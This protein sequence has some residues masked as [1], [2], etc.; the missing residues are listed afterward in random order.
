M[1][2]RI[3]AYDSFKECNDCSLECSPKIVHFITEHLLNNE[4]FANGSSK[5]CTIVAGVKAMTTFL[6]SEEEFNQMRSKLISIPEYKAVFLSD[7]EGRSGS[8]KSKKS[9]ASVEGNEVATA[10][11]SSSSAG[12]ASEQFVSLMRIL[13]NCIQTQG[14]ELHSI[15]VPNKQSADKEAFLQL[16]SCCAMT[17]IKL[18]NF[19]KLISVDEWHQ[20]AWT[21]LNPSPSRRAEIWAV[22][23]GIIQT[24]PVHSKFLAYPCLLASDEALSAGAGAALQKAISRLRNTHEEMCARLVK[25]DSERSRKMAEQCIPEAVLPYVLHLLS[26]H[27]DFPTTPECESESDQRRL[28][29][30]MRSIR[31]VITALQASLRNEA[32]NISYLLKQLNLI[33]Q[34]Y[35]DKMDAENIGLHFVAGVA[36]TMLQD[37]VKTAENVQVYPGEIT[38]PGDLFELKPEPDEEQASAREELEAR[39]AVAEIQPMIDKAIQ[40]AGKQRVKALPKYMS[41]PSSKLGF[42]AAVHR[43]GGSNSNRSVTSSVESRRSKY[44]EEKDHDADS[45]IAGRGLEEDDEESSIKKPRGK[46]AKAKK[47]AARPLPEEVKTRSLPSRRAKAAVASYKEAEVSE[48]EVI[49]W[50][51]EAGEAKGA[52]KRSFGKEEERSDSSAVKSSAF[53]SMKKVANYNIKEMLEPIPT[54]LMTLSAQKTVEQGGRKSHVDLSRERSSVGIGISGFGDLARRRESELDLEIAEDDEF[55]AFDNRLSRDSAEWDSMLGQ[56]AEMKPLQ[57]TTKS[58]TSSVAPLP[59]K[60]PKARSSKQPLVPTEVPAATKDDAKVS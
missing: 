37:Q 56:A 17:M 30:V 39:T 23:S 12:Q 14:E 58:R 60:A 40:K 8:L 24:Y 29:A 43:S 27:P 44:E 50:D 46:K 11:T 13:F 45:S 22:L 57:H 52:R 4:N 48:K 49:G 1:N 9:D 10:S 34:F 36:R 32:S 19:A 59:L 21:L 3:F 53:D 47:E 55:V 28:K 7:Q 6:V 33:S 42:K 26:Y 41:P 5:Q 15:V 16:S 2:P 54:S 51:E 20:L 25:A 18:V 38:L 35:N 31:I